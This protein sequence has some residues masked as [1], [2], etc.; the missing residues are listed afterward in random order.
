MSE[1]YL[2]KASRRSHATGGFELFATLLFSDIHSTGI[3]TTPVRLTIQSYV[4]CSNFERRSFWFRRADQSSRAG[5]S[6][7]RLAWSTGKITFQIDPDESA[8]SF[9][10]SLSSRP[11]SSRSNF[12]K[13]KRRIDNGSS[14]RLISPS[15]F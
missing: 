9:T 12:L 11:S 3:M 8:S 5:P 4:A 15:S 10:S 6:M 1:E 14:S 7:A 13:A 2:D